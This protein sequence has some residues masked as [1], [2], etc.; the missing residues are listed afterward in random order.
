MHKFSFRA[1]A[2]YL[3]IAA[4][5]LVLLA[6]LGR[7]PGVRVGDG[8]EYYGLYYA[9]AFG[10]RPWMTPLAFDGYS[11]LES[12]QAI[13]ALVPRQ[14]LAD[15]FPA[16]R[17][18]AT[19]DF[20][21]FWAYSLVAVIC[22]KLASLVGIALTVHQGF[23]AVHLIAMGVTV[24]IAYRYFRWKGVLAVV[25]MLLAS[26][27]FWF[28]NKAHTEYVTVCLVLSGVILMRV[29]RYLAAALC[30]A[31]A[32]TQNPSFAL[33]A[34]IPFFYRVVF[35]RAQPYRLRDVVMVVAVVL[36][37]LLHPA[38]YFSR[39]GVV[40]PQLLAGGASMG[41]NLSTFYIWIFDPDL[42]LLPNWPM[43]LAILLGALGILA[44]RRAPQAGTV[45]DARAA[46]FSKACWTGF[47]VLYL[48]INL[49]AHSST[50]N[51][52]SGA[53]PG[54]ARYALWY[55]PLG[56]PV[57]IYVFNM[58]PARTT[59][60]HAG[61]AAL[62]VLTV[63][64]TRVN[65]PRSPERY[66]QSSLS[67]RFIQANLPG[68][69]DPPPEVFMERY[70][71]FGED[72]YTHN[73][74]AVVGPDCVKVLIMPAPGSHDG[75]APAACLYDM[76]KLNQLV[77]QGM[78][79]R[80]AAT[81]AEAL[82]HYLRLDAAQAKSLGRT[83]PLGHHVIGSDGDGG[84]VLGTGW[85]AR[86]PWGVWSKSPV[87]TL[88]LPCIAP[89]TGA[90]LNLTIRP[91]D[92]Q[93]VTIS[94]EK[95]HLWKGALAAGDQTLRLVLPPASCVRGRH[96]VTLDIPGAVSPLKLGMSADGRDLGVGLVA[97]EMQPR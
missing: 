95:T 82:P 24:S 68:L 46:G 93:Q 1:I 69:Y 89:D 47:V 97:F 83:A 4:A 48:A 59:R 73:L 27:M 72:I 81:A 96:L 15:A 60:R 21:H 51:L 8:S 76:E 31:L 26:P 43:G 16:L 57:F 5:L 50:Q 20:N 14:A 64:S 41:A 2:P 67:S 56:F 17:I 55:L 54:L 36:A 38:Y 30:M 9:W 28:I 84:S 23:V 70:S 32:S 63:V 61:L 12:M 13:H 19:A 75:I 37:V 39:Y 77:N 10:H 22:V 3:A 71:G 25:L 42:G 92:K 44:L 35:Q 90:V 94:S 29:D 88:L 49:Y 80:V 11:A 87:A 86:E 7:I 65:D 33:I 18:G 85:H 45:G 66:S 74:R 53:T 79:V 34:F 58:F 52:N 62:A 78:G 91:F 6:V 40:T